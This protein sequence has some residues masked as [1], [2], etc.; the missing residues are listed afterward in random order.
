MRWIV[1][2]CCSAE[3]A[4]C[5]GSDMTEHALN[6]RFRY[7]RAHSEVIIEGRKANLDVKNLT[8]DESSLPKT[9]GGVDKNSTRQHFLTLNCDRSSSRHLNIHF[10]STFQRSKG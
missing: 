8:T 5:Y 7:I 3:I 10:N 9:V 4:A 2:D 6:H 1:I